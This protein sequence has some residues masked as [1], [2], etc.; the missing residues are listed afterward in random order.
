M[1]GGMEA[2][3]SLVLLQASASTETTNWINGKR[4]TGRRVCLTDMISVLTL[5]D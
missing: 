4:G 3:W 5:L 2:S 1:K